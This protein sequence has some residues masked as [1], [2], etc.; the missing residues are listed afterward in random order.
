[1]QYRLPKKPLLPILLAGVLVAAAI[2]FYLLS[3]PYAALVLLFPYLSAVVIVAVLYL[4]GRY[5]VFDTVY[6]L[7]DGYTDLTLTILRVHQ[8]TSTPIAKI[9]LCGNETIVLLDKTGKRTLKKQK[10]LGV[11]TVNLAPKACYALTCTLEGE[12]GYVLLELDAYAEKTLSDRIKRA[13]AIY[14]IDRP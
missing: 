2:S 3:R 8:R 12:E 13:K 6:R 11:Y 9:E 1:M 7:G 14:T 10:K 4:F 5:L